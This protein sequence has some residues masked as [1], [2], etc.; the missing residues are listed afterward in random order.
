[1]SRRQRLTSYGTPDVLWLEEYEPPAPGPGQVLVRAEASTV[2]FTDTLIRRGMYPGL[3]A[4]PPLTPGYDLVGVIEQVGE[5]VSP[6]RVGERV[7]DLMGH[8]GQAE[9]VVLDVGRAV[10][11]DTE[12]GSDLLAP[13]VL[14]GVT[15]Y[16]M[17]HRIA[18]VRPGERVL[19]QGGTGAVG[20]LAV[21]LARAHGCEVHATASLR[22]HEALREMGVRPWDYAQPEW[23]EALVR[24][25]GGG[26]DHVF[27]GA[28]AN[29]FRDAR[30]ATR[31]GGRLWLLG[32]SELVRRRAPMWE[33]AWVMAR[34]LVGWNLWPDG[35]GVKLYGV[36][37][38]RASRPEWFEQDVRALVALVEQGVL[39]VEVEARLGIEDVPRAHRELE[40]GGTHGWR[41]VMM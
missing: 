41:V 35:R 32:F 22:N 13:L 7:L 9:Y 30:R 29:G 37:Q 14:S 25:T 16:Q 39:E 1:M 8:G 33:F 38:L 10:R 18:K 20:R 21:Q 17:L 40:A 4:K 11:V 27:D 6:E 26:V 28:A 5:G 36:R 12:L 15:A 23:V 24:E 31:P 19:I 2:S 3:G 34:A